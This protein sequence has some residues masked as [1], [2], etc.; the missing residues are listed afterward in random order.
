M[1]KIGISCVRRIV[2]KSLKGCYFHDFNF[3]L[4]VSLIFIVYIYNTIRH[5]QY[6][7]HHEFFTAG[8]LEARVRRTSAFRA[9]AE[10]SLVMSTNES[11]F[12]F[13]SHSNPI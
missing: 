10:F 3:P 12:V 13:L 1:Q 7:I 11:S 4:V 2:L 9:P 8:A 5:M 6:A